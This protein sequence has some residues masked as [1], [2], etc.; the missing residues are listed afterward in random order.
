LRVDSLMLGNIRVS[1]LISIVIF[2]LGI[3]LLIDI[4]R[5]HKQKMLETSEEESSLRKIVEVIEA[6]DDEET[7]Q[8]AEA[9]EAAKQAELMAYELQDENT[10]RE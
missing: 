4:R 9:L 6:S 1:R 8:E 7:M 3:A 2:V 10:E 5:R